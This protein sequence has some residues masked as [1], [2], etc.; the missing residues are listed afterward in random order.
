MKMKR[1]ATS[2]AILTAGTAAGL[3]A[4]AATLSAAPSYT[5]TAIPDTPG[6]SAGYAYAINDSGTVVGN[7]NT[8][9]GVQHAFSYSNGTTTDLGTL[10]GNGGTLAYGINE[11]GTV[12]GWGYTAS[13]AYHAFSYSNGTM[14]DLVV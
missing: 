9:S 6:G 2:M 1:S 13:G 11:S 5:F 8:A 12:V 14:T 10:G 3:F 4:S 7:S